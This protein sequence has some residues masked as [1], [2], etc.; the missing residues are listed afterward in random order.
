MTSCMWNHF[1]D[2]QIDSST[3][4]K[5][6]QQKKGYLMTQDCLHFDKQL[7]LL[8]SSWSKNEWMTYHGKKVG[9]LISFSC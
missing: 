7:L 1:S 5:M 9:K 4:K 6:K 3:L 2:I 8:F